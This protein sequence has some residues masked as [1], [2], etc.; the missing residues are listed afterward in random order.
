MN[1]QLTIRWA[2]PDDAAIITS[3]RR[4][5]F[6]DMG[7]DDKDNLDAM[8]ARYIGWVRAKIEQG[9]YHGWLVCDGDTVV[10]GAGLWEMDAPPGPQYAGKRGYV[11]NV[12]TEPAY[13]RQGL[14]RRLMQAILDWCKEEN[15][16]VVSLHASDKARPL[17]EMLGFQRTNEMR[18][19]L[20]S[21]ER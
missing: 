17:Y 7:F 2:K 19:R 5:M 6:E 21:G 10:A 8:D 9:T 18:I 4:R 3:H 16:M 11:Y 20:Q 12:F 15:I 1:K 14:A 13:R